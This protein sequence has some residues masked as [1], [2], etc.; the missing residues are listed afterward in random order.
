MGKMTK[1]L[2]K[3]KQ[4][5][6]G[7]EDSKKTWCLHI[8]CDREMVQR[9]SMP[10]DYQNLLSFFKKN[11]GESEIAVMYEAGFKGFELHD[12]LEEDGIR[13]EVVPPTSVTEAKVNRVKTDKGDAVRLAKMLA[14]GDYTSC[15]VP[16]RERRQD[17][18]V[19]RLYDQI[20][21]DIVRQKNRIRGFLKFHGLESHVSPGRWTA[22]KYL[23]L[24]TLSLPDSLRFTLHEQLDN[25]EYLIAHKKKVVDKFYELSRK[26]RYKNAV[27]I[28]MS[29]PG[30]GRL[31]AVKLTLEWG[32][33]ERFESGKKLASYIGLTPSEY[34]TGETIRRGRITGQGNRRV[35][36][37][38]IE[39]A[40]RA[41]YKDDVLMAKF[42]KVKGNKGSAKKA[43]VAVARKLL[44]RMYALEKKNEHY[45][46]GV[47]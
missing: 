31:T 10:A 25:L 8:L 7:L 18:H 42:L 21:T 1:T 34:S 2:L 22:K 4:I 29:V 20:I 6:V 26:E 24:R 12:M 17:R 19:S 5:F 14:A 45:M 38:L 9:T 40:W 15:H 36:S 23:S 47:A 13:C 27:D 43:I 30:I 28:K 33:L 35:R 37:C 46:C 32:N 41:I 39:C 11:Y 44:I 3:G 16:S